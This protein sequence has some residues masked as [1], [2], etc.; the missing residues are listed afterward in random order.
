MGMPLY[1]ADGI[2]LYD[3]E[4]EDDISDSEVDWNLVLGEE[5]S[6][7]EEEED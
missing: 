5:S 1:D 2:P 3:A 7:S 6:D 4:S